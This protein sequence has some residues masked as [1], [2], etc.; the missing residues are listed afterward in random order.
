MRPSCD[1][2]VTAGSA[3]IREEGEGSGRQAFER[4]NEEG[5]QVRAPHTYMEWEDELRDRRAPP[6][7]ADKDMATSKVHG[8]L[9]ASLPKI[10][11]VMGVRVK[12]NTQHPLRE[13]LSNAAA[14]KQS[15]RHAGHS[16]HLADQHGPRQAPQPRTT[17]QQR[18]GKKGSPEERR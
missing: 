15:H 9:W 8:F 1:N 2:K 12:A 14:A 13:L 17:K 16:Q 18:Q 5:G 11:Q 4:N 10:P 7:S 6:K 3:T